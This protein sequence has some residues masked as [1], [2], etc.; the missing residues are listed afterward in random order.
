MPMKPCGFSPRMRLRRAVDFERVYQTGSTSRDALMRT[1]VAPNGLEFSRLGLS[2]GRVYGDAV[3][4]NRFKRLTRE[5]FRL[6]RVRLPAGFDII[7]IPARTKTE[8]SRQ[9]VSDSLLKLACDA[10]GKSEKARKRI[11]N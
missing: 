9:A 5:A 4:R 10:A 11:E 2:V 8:P 6:D 1:V 7:V 3:R